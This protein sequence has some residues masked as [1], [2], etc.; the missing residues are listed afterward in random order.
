MEVSPSL[1]EDL[2]RE[3]A[4]IQSSIRDRV[5]SAY[6]GAS[7]PRLSS[8]AED[9]EG[10][11]I[12]EVDRVS[13]R[14]LLP[15]FDDLARGVGGIVL[16][17]EGLPGGKV[18]LPAGTDPEAAALRVIVDPID[19]TRGLMYQKRSAWVLTGVA[20]NRGE[21]TRLSDIVL[22]AQTEIPVGKQ[23][24][25]DQIVAIAGRGVSAGRFDRVR[26]E[27]QSLSLRPSTET[28]VLHGFSTIARFFPGTGAVLGAFEDDFMRAQLGEP[29]DGKALSF[30]DQYI[31]T[32]GQ[33]YELAA[34]H[35]RFVADLRPLAARGGGPRAPRPLCCHPYD[36][37][38]ALVA[39]EL[40]VVIRSPAGG[41]LDC[42][43][44]VDTDVAWV[45]YAN[46]ALR[47]RVE[48]LL[49]RTLRAH[50]LLGP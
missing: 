13:E 47:Q 8:V 26:G 39:T 44:D 1:L 33:L 2:A 4:R 18:T 32:G 3:V 14:A 10:D 12:Y 37:C 21:G 23:H 11:T 6:E 40:G 28:T 36:V 43:L 20:P 41:P 50:G 31:S 42:V 17:A 38:T 22:A 27:T 30:E 5:I 48:P 16:V 15:L 49:T 46:D 29:R 9:G 45:G 7:A 25:A 19:G 34:G 35:D 24:L